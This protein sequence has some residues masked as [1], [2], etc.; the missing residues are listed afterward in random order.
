MSADAE[1]AFPTL[2]LTHSSTVDRVAEELRRAVFEGELESGT[3]LREVALAD[4]LGVAR[5]TVREALGMLVAE[6]I[7]TREP[8]RGVWVTSPDP[9]SVTDVIRARTVLELAGVRAWPTATDAARTEVRRALDAYAAAVRTGASYQ[10]LNE[11]HLTIHLS[12][13]ALTGSPRLVAMAESLIAEL[14]VALAQI[15]RIRRNS[16]DQ[17]GSHTHLLHL[18]EDDD[19]DG[20]LAALTEHL[21]DADVAIQSAL[22]LESS[23]GDDHDTRPHDPTA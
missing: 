6:G 11:R 2:N 4:S 17:A 16:H 19:I 7:A 8:N 18:L 1:H 12:L 13:V 10:Q 5:S 20:A 21:A 22:G 3:P 9:E 23:P 14:K 15:D